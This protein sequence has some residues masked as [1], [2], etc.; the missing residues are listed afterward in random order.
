MEKKI[1]SNGPLKIDHMCTTDSEAPPTRRRHGPGPGP[2]L[3]RVDGPSKIDHMC[4]R[5]A[6]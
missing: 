1:D 5:K 6:Q 2:A 4:T 3:L